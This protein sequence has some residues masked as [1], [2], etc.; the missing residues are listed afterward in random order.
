MPDPSSGMERMILESP[1]DKHGG[2]E[3][4]Q[5]QPV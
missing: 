5:H 1:D 4:D 3:C 2:I